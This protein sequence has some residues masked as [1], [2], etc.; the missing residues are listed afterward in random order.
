MALFLAVPQGP[1]PR[2][3]RGECPEDRVVLIVDIRRPMP[4]P[5]GAINRA[6]QAVMRQLY[7]K[8]ILK[9]LA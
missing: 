3:P 4:L 9:K 1:V 7:G 8:E 2:V 5:F 6:A